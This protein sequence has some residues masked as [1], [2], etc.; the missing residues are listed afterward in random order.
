MYMLI[1][2]SASAITRSGIESDIGET[3]GSDFRRHTY[4]VLIVT[5]VGDSR[6]NLSLRVFDER[7]EV[8]GSLLRQGLDQ[9]GLGARDRRRSKEG[10]QNRKIW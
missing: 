7:P 6:T 5:E 1:V 2:P 8:D 4:P 10:E 9:I 3:N